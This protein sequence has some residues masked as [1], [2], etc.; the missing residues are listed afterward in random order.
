MGGE[1]MTDSVLTGQVSHRHRYFSESRPEEGQM[2]REKCGMC[3]LDAVSP[4]GAQCGEIV[5]FSLAVQ[6]AWRHL[7]T[8]VLQIKVDWWMDGFQSTSWETFG[9]VA[10]SITLSSQST[11][12]R[13]PQ[14]VLFWKL[15]PYQCLDV[16]NVAKTN[17]KRPISKY[18]YQHLN[19]RYEGAER[20]W[21]VFTSHHEVPVVPRSVPF[22]WRDLEG[23]AFTGNEGRVGPPPPHHHHHWRC[24]F[25]SFHFFFFHWTQ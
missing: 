18:W 9:C 22:R 1:R 8:V 14:P 4:E 15:F 20:L 12:F 11:G 21:C 19:G 3:I 2:A 7:S 25:S 10:E 17:P 6:S 24:P 23:A 16:G 13:K 5:F